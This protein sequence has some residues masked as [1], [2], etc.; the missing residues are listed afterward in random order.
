MVTFITMFITIAAATAAITYA[1][2]N[3]TEEQAAA[4][5]EQLAATGTS[6]SKII[7]TVGGSFAIGL[8]IQVHYVM[9]AKKLRDNA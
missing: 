3:M 5:E 1:T 8:L 4:Y 2:Q 7:T 9:V 6:K